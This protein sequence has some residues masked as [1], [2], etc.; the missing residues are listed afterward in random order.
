MIDLERIRIPKTGNAFLL[1]FHLSEYQML[2][3]K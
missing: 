2:N 3:I 1:L